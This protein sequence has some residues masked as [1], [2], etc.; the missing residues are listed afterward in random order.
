MQNPSEILPVGDITNTK[1]ATVLATLGLALRKPGIFIT[2]DKANPQSSGGTAHF[3]FETVMAAKVLQY[4]AIYEEGKSDSELDEFVDRLRN[5][6]DASLIAELEIK[7]SH[8]LITYGR[9]FL[10]NYTEI[11]KSLKHDT[12]RFSVVGG[13]PVFSHGKLVAI[14]D[15]TVKGVKR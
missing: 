14:E 9:R 2:Y 6:I 8:A 5:L 1:Q 13:T 12:G 3:L 10:D 15:F 4:V 11:V 7:I